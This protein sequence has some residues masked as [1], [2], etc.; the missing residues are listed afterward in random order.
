M[1][2]QLQ[3]YLPLFQP[4]TPFPAQELKGQ[5]GQ[6]LVL[7]FLSSSMENWEIQREKKG[8]CRARLSKEVGTALI[9]SLSPLWEFHTRLQGPFFYYCCPVLTL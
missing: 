4:H 7:C 1:G 9:T 5:T 3:K 6:L 2:L 8:I